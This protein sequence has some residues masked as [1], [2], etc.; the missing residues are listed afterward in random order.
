M[1]HRARGDALTVRERGVEPLA[2]GVLG[3]LEATA[4]GIAISAPNIY[5]WSKTRA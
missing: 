5:A 2:I 3:A 4:S 1:D